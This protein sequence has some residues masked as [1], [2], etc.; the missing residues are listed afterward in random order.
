[1]ERSG[2]SILIWV[3]QYQGEFSNQN[4]HGIARVIFKHGTVFEGLYINDKK[5]GKG[6]L[7]FPNGDI[8]E[9]TWKNGA[10]FGAG[11]LT[12]A[13]TGLEIQ[14]IWNEDLKTKYSKCV[15]KFPQ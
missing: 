5:E 3:F 15:D 14:Q 13:S 2:K 9:G 7:L 8:F 10:R 12:Q 1:M 6:K 11:V 4:R